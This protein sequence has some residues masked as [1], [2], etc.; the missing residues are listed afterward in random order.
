MITFIPAKD[1]AREQA[2]TLFNKYP[3]LFI[4]YYEQLSQQIV[5]FSL[6]DIKIC[7]N[8]KKLSHINTK[9]IIPF[10][11]L[12]SQNESKKL[13]YPTFLI[14]S[15]ILCPYGTILTQNL[16]GSHAKHL[17]EINDFLNGTCSILLRCLER[18][19]IEFKV[20]TFYKKEINS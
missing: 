6:I 20:S 18:S 19:P 9:V 17:K 11:E 13:G 3:H 15:F 1:S 14:L 8:E 12:L 4:V 5:F 10:F 7:L 2:Y 16:Y